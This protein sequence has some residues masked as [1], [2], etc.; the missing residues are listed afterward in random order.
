[1]NDNDNTENKLVKSEEE[2]RKELSPEEFEVLRNAGTDP[3]FYRQI[4][5]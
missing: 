1:M 5:R 4:C 2:W 3:A